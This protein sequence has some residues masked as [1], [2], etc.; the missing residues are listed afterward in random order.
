ME[1]GVCVEGYLDVFGVKE[2][3][4]GYE[5]CVDWWEWEDSLGGGFGIFFFY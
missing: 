1:R 4:I 5:D 3:V 2:G